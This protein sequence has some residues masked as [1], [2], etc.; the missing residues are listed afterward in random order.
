[1]QQSLA[2]DFGPNW[3]EHFRSFDTNPIASA[4]IGQVYKAYLKDG[5][6]VA[7]KVLIPGIDSKFSFDFRIYRW[8]SVLL[9]RFFPHIDFV[10]ST[11]TF[12]T[13]M[14]GELDYTQEARNTAYFFKL[15]HIPGI[16]S[17]EIIEELCSANTI[18]TKWIEGN[19]LT[20]YLEHANEMTIKEVLTRLQSSFLQQVLRLGCFQGD[21]HPGNFII[22]NR[23]NIY[24]VDFGCM[25]RLDISQRKV[26]LRIILAVV[27]KNKEAL[28]KALLDGGIALPPANEFADQLIDL[29]AAI[30]SQSNE[31][32]EYK[33]LEAIV[34]QLIESFQGSNTQIPDHFLIT[35]RVL[36][37]LTGLFKLY[38]VKPEEIDFESLLFS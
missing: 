29:L 38:G 16:K 14:Q 6:A 15:E 35:G 2:T 12:L 18:T 13:S 25:G 21:P 33:K 28:N 34:M 31:F 4:S 27:D 36:I 23:N 10:Q 9:Q 26:Y 8:A 32:D 3:S 37:T 19:T 22:D 30:G 11:N 17:P 1:M 24:I 7:V 5:T 20:T